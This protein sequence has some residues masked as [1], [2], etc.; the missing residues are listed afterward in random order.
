MLLI[1]IATLVYYCAYYGDI[2]LWILHSEEHAY[3]ILTAKIPRYS[4]WCIILRYTLAYLPH[5]DQRSPFLQGS[6]ARYHDNNS[7]KVSDII[8]TFS[9]TY[10]DL[11]HD[12]KM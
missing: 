6:E 4:Y 7:L 2:K 9:F 5:L 3:P 8:P 12:P 10:I 11:Q 1:Y